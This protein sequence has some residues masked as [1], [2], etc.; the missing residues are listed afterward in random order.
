MKKN[1]FSFIEIKNAEWFNEILKFIKNAKI[2][3]EFSNRAEFAKAMYK[4]IEKDNRV[5]FT[6]SVSISEFCEIISNNEDYYR[7]IINTISYNEFGTILTNLFKQDP[8][9]SDIDYNNL[10][11]ALIYLALIAAD[12]DTKEK[13]ST[14][15]VLNAA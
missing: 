11:N 13:L 15:G 8:N 5:N 10:I 1:N 2:R 12:F 4:Y 3:K 7:E 14:L 9:T 6:E